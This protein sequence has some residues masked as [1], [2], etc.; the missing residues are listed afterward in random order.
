MSF[1]KLFNFFRKKKDLFETFW[2]CE[3]PKEIGVLPLIK[4]LVHS[5][6]NSYKNHFPKNKILST[7]DSA[8]I[9][10]TDKHY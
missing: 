10:I 5:W 9:Y 8:K 3:S 2:T 7:K 4:Y 6:E 1:T